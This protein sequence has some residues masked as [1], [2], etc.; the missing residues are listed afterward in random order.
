M[1]RRGFLTTG[2]AA[3]AGVIS[4]GVPSAKGQSSEKAKILGINC[5]PR[6]GKTTCK[7]LETC[8]QAAEQVSSKIETQLIE[9]G[10][11]DIR[12][13][14]ACMECKKGLK[15]S[16]EDDFAKLIPTLAD[17]NVAGMIIGTPVYFGTMTSQCKAFLD[18]CGM[19]RFNNWIF[20]NRIGGTL[21]VGSMRNGGQEITLQEV[22]T[23]LLCHD[24]ICVSEGKDTAHFGAT[25]VSGGEGGIEADT[26]GLKTAGNLGRR[27]AELA[28][29]VN[30]GTAGA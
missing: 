28:L 20:R 19:F 12:G 1:D 5:S 18:R 16:I 13:C 7:A 22:R 23:V 26:F 14:N 24:M 27:V 17:K 15:C 11:L 29:L 10:G 2:L 9:L 3:G 21:A 25:L 6:K 8:L 30:S 4:A